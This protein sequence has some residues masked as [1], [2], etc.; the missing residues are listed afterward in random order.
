MWALVNSAAV[1]RQSLSKPG[2][3]LV[4]SER[5]EAFVSM[6]GCLGSLRTDIEVTVGDAT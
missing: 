4:W 6:G 3:F 2:N 1:S 5:F